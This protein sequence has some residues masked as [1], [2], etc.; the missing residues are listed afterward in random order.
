MADLLQYY[1]FAAAGGVVYGV[2][3]GT[4]KRYSERCPG[5]LQPSLMRQ[6]GAQRRAAALEMAGYRRTS[7]RSSR[8]SAAGDGQPSSAVAVVK[9]APG[10]SPRQA[11]VP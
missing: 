4:V 7:L 1:H 9:A 10:P 6:P 5:G 8:R 2:N 3:W 11:G